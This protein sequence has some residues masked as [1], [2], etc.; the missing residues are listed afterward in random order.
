VR[1]FKTFEEAEAAKIQTKAFSV[2]SQEG[3]EGARRHVLRS[4]R[5]EAPGALT[6][7]QYDGVVHDLVNFL[8]WMGEPAQES[9]KQIG[10]VVLLFL[11]LLVLLSW[12]L[13]KSYWKDVH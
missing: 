6:P 11:G 7:A 3:E 12:L 8:A 13:Y 5:P 2:L 1:E 10:I 4:V 9:R